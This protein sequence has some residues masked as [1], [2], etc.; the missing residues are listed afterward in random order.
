MNG[1][2][3]NNKKQAVDIQEKHLL[4]IGWK[5]QKL[6]LDE[7]VRQVH[8]GQRVHGAQ[9]DLGEKTPQIV[10]GPGVVGIQPQR[11]VAIPEPQQQ[12]DTQQ[13][14]QGRQ[15]ERRLRRGTDQVRQ[16]REKQDSQEDQYAA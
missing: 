7:V 4:L 8:A 13:P 6:A 14:G 3:R 12:R 9:D 10:G 15:I 16:S 2:D 11:N 1:Y 5:T